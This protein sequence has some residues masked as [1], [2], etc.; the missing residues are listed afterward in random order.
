MTTAIIGAGAIGSVLAANFVRGGEDVV[1]A[2]RSL[3]H[4]QA[5][6]DNVGARASTVA[7]AITEADKVVFAV[8]F[9][10]AKDLLARYA[11]KLGGKTI[12]DPSNPVTVDGDGGFTKTIARDESAGQV[13]A[14]LVPAD[15]RF[16]K[17]FGTQSAPTLAGGSGHRPPTAQF[18][19]TDHKEA[20]AAVAELIKTGGYAPVLIG[21]IDQSI[22]I[23][24]FGDLHETTLGS[25][26][27]EGEAKKLI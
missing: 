20:G 10:V 13:L 1:L 5:V 24:V 4:A 7:D 22:R 23:E 12:I 3:K 15:A 18:H 27:T 17:A 25:T 2:S 8:W 19:A 6:A 14:A 16:A 11:G 9:D 21:G 26:V